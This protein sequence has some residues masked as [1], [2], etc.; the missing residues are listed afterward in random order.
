MDSLCSDIVRHVRRSLSINLLTVALV[1]VSFIP[2]CNLCTTPSV[3][4]QTASPFAPAAIIKNDQGGPIAIRGEVSYTNAFFTIGTEAPM[5]ILED[6]AGFVDRDQGYILPIESQ[7]IGQ[8]TSDF[9]TSPFSYSIS[10]PIEPL[11]SLRDVDNDGTDDIGVMIFAI[12]YRAN[13]FGDP[14]LEERDLFGGGWSTS[15]ASTRVSR[16]AEAFR[17]IIGGSFLVYAPDDEQ[18]FPSGFGDDD[19]L[20]TTDDPTVR[21]PQGYVIVNMDSDPFS[22]ERSNYPVIDLIE[23]EDR[24]MQD[25]SALAYDDAFDALIDLLSDEYAFTDYKQVDWETLRVA[26]RPRFEEAEANNDDLAFRRALRDF[27]FSIPDGHVSGPFVVEDFRL[28]TGG[29]LGMAIRELDN[30]DV[31][32]NF[33]LAEGPADRAGIVEGAEIVSMNGIPIDEFV[34]ETVALSAPFSTAHFERLQKLRY[35]MRSPLGT[36]FDVV[37]QNPGAQ[38]PI[39]V[40]LKS[41]AETESFSFSSFNAGIDGFQL[42]VE[43]T[44]LDNAYG[45]AKIYSFS[46]NKLLTIQLWERLVHTLKNK[47]VPGLII[48]MRQNG[49]GSAFLADQMAAYF[50]DEELALASI[51]YYDDDLGK[52]YF[53]P[54]TVNQFYLPP[55]DLRYDGAVAVL[56]GPNCNS[57]C[58]FFVRDMAL[59]D[60]AAIVGHYP[61]AGLGGTI[62]VALMP[63]DIYFQYSEGRVVDLNGE[64]LIEGKGIAPTI[65]VPV[66]METLLSDGDPELEASIRHLDGLTQI[67]FIDAGDLKLDRSVTGKLEPNVRVRYTLSLGAGDVVNAYLEDSTGRLDTVLRLYDLS[68]ALLASNDDAET[69]ETVNSSIE[70]F[71]IPTDLTLIV[72]VST[73]GDALSGDYILT[74]EL[75][76]EVDT[77]NILEEVVAVD[78]FASSPPES[79]PEPSDSENDGETDVVTDDVVASDVASSSDSVNDNVIEQTS[80]DGIIEQSSDSAPVKIAVVRTKGARL[81]VRS[82]PSS[83]FPRIGYVTDG[84][85]HQVLELSADRQWIK[86]VLE[87]IEHNKADQETSGWISID[88]V[89]YEA[90]P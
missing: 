49:G 18:G 24:G 78:D 55:D 1:T 51:G 12:A 47:S 52:F 17:E 77:K 88:Y 64:V 81:S 74:V 86:V 70:H 56:A 4:A 43:Y 76:A 14:F 36:V 40:A 2:T 63:H 27:S 20:F 35:A 23:P 13:V 62:N 67:E 72:E 42:P 32:V 22:F 21:I 87:G 15:Y 48:D 33:V 79:I 39:T 25:F 68:D 37:Y 31:I 73:Y 29:G 66:N 89:E 28:E 75:D 41:E 71:E 16:E 82:G 50:H 8:I 65:R 5:V 34:E 45:Y 46:D 58:E 59:R 7:T 19:R 30:G 85:G 44:Q 53:D 11:A 84:S 6:Q 9:H 80:N 54:Q 61:T 10:L 3:H 57:A 69:H 60:R 83:D 90:E 26:F 38:S